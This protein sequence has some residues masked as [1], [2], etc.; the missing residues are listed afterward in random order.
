MHVLTN[1]LMQTIR[2]KYS[3]ESR[4]LVERV[5]VMYDKTI[6]SCA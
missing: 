2:V 5:S 1:L 6:V 3:S 4:V